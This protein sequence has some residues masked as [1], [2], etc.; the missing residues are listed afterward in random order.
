MSWLSGSERNSVHHWPGNV[1]AVDEAL[2]RA[3]GALVEVV[4][5]GFSGV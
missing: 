4:A 3:A 2:R 1:L 5:A